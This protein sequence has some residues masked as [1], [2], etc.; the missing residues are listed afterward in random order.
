MNLL[1]TTNLHHDG[2][3][4]SV[5]RERHNAVR[6]E[7]DSSD[8]AELLQATDTAVDADEQHR[9]LQR[10]VTEDDVPNAVQSL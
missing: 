7:G 2:Q 1:D 5:E 9:D 6:R 3:N 8:R 10:V 4:G